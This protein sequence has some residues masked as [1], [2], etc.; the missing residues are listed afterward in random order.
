MEHKEKVI[1]M[2]KE[3]ARDAYKALEVS[4]DSEYGSP[5]RELFAEKY[6]RRQAYGRVLRELFGVQPE[7]LQ[8]IL[9]ILQN[10]QK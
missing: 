1:E 6:G 2:Y 5:E 10:P 8:E 3:A 7:E 9:D 4:K